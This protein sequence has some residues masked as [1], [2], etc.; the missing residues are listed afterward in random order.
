[1]GCLVRS[2]LYRISLAASPLVLLRCVNVFVV[3]V[4]AFALALSPFH[5][6]LQAR[7]SLE[8]NP[9]V[10][11]I[12]IDDLGYSD[13]G[14]FGATRYETPNLDR[15]AR[16]GRCFTDFVVSSAV[17][18]ASRAALLTGCLHERVGFRGALGPNAKAG[19]AERETTIAE[20][21]KTKDYAT[22]CF[23]K[24]HLGHYPKFLPTQHGFDHY[25]GL[26]YSNDM[27]PFHPAAIAARNKDPKSP[28]IYPALP[29]VEGN[30]VVD[31]DV[32]ADDQKVMTRDYTARAVS[33]IEANAHRPFFLYLPHSM[34]HVPLY[35]SPEFEGKHAAGPY[36]DAVRE[37]DWSVGQILDTLQRLEL[38]ERTLVIFTS[39]NGPW[40]S[41][42]E[43][44]GAAGPLREGK[45]TAWEG[46]VRV[47][48]IMQMPGRIPGGTVCDKLASTIDVLPT[49]AHLIGAE[50]PSL[51][52]DGKSILPLMVSDSPSPHGSIPYYY[53]DGQLQ[54]IRNERWKLVFP[55]QYRSVAGLKR[56]S[57]GNPVDYKNQKVEKPELYDLDHDVSE[58]INV[59]DA[60]PEQAEALKRLA[61]QWRNELGDSLTGKK[62]SAI[63]PMDLHEAKDPELSER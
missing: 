8:G 56:R 1:M 43:H 4:F 28:S 57:D 32:T 62:G 45:G 47:P 51:P 42:G 2:Q 37:V 34:V 3:G 36:A 41:Y 10:V 13:I 38:T 17:C 6:L 55:H 29:M 50:L 18:S 30:R 35:S 21:C 40:L 5:S 19:I 53:A 16:E 52:I 22:A 46:G 12:F 24:W 59:I 27:W 15:M 14:P 11:L 61:D 63:R 33:F 39:D 54:A 25:Y 7:E 58:S 9:N 49:V 60:N 44:A 23:G 26:P 20:L 31:S 48:T